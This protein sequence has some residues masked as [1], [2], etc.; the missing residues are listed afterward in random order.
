MNA[1][2]VKCLLG[3][4]QIPSVAKVELIYPDGEASAATLALRQD[5]NWL[6]LIYE[7]FTFSSP[8]VNVKF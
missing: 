7:N 4:D 6:R 2:F 8:T 1:N 5:R 3:V